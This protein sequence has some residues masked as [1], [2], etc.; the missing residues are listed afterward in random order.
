MGG[1]SGRARRGAVSLLV[2]VP[3]LAL[4]LTRCGSGAG[5]PGRYP[6]GRSH[7]TSWPGGG[8]LLDSSGPS[9]STKEPAC[10]SPA[11]LALVLGVSWP[12]RVEHEQD[13]HD[14]N[15]DGSDDDPLHRTAPYGADGA[16]HQAGTA[17]GKTSR[18]FDACRW[19]GSQ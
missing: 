10:R 6:A 12:P 14:P 1:K 16:A 15:D 18:A 3:F 4:G 7:Q 9:S 5:W 13:D 19:A 2:C 8:G 17:P 11:R